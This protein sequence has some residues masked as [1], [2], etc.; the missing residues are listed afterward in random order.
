M[1]V[2]PKRGM[3]IIRI[4]SEVIEIH[5]MSVKIMYQKMFFSRDGR[6]RKLG[7]V[8]TEEGR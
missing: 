6:T 2:Y 3:I 4:I 5:Y 8:S 1:S 7:P